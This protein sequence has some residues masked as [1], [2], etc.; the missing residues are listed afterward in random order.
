MKINLSNITEKLMH[1]HPKIYIN[2]ESI[3]TINS[4]KY[5]E[6]N[7]TVFDTNTLYIG[8]VSSLSTFSDSIPQINLLIVSEVK[9]P[10]SFIANTALNIILIVG[11][12]VL[13]VFNEVL[14]ILSEC[15]KL[16]EG[17]SQLLE[18]LSHSNDIQEI[19]DLGYKLI[20]NPIFVRDISFKVLAFTQNIKLDDHVWNHIISKGYQPFSAFQFLTKHGFIDT[21]NNT[22]LPI[23]FK[24]IDPVKDEFHSKKVMTMGIN[25]NLSYI[26]KPIFDP[27]NR[28]SISRV[29]SNICIGNKIIGQVVALE[30]FKSFSETDIALMKKLSD[31]ISQEMQKQ[32]YYKNFSEHKQDLIITDLLDEKIK[33][34]ETLEE[35]LK[36]ISWNLKAPMRVITVTTNT[37]NISEFSLKYIR[38]FFKDLFANTTCILYEGCIVVIFSCSA[39]KELNDIQRQTLNKFMLETDMFSGVSRDFSNLL[40]VKKHYA[41]ALNAIKSGKHLNDDKVLFFYEDYILQHIFNLC[42]AEES[43]K[44]MCHPSIFTLIKYDNDNS[45][46]YVKNL[47]SYIMTFKS[48]SEL[49]SLLHIHRNT[50]YYRINKI[51]TIMNIDLSNIDNYFSIYLSFKILEYLGEDLS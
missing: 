46:S 11:N 33:D 37:K 27:E 4:T 13:S 39:G 24:N 5:L 30:S 18:A 17:S 43:L 16:T 31:T 15:Q 32:K 21:A 38:G 50:M 47:Y 42:T 22:V 26:I 2:N 7:I 28:I 36:Y 10:D 12:S 48:P 35:R 19:I 44:E 9:V 14:D 20:G 25:E 41:E 34:Q 23:Y 3:T 6:K 1:Y 51:E 40:D 8:D 29:W 49:A 45:T